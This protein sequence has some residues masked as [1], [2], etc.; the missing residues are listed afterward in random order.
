MMMKTNQ[1]TIKD[2]IQQRCEEDPK[3]KEAW[4]NRNP[5]GRITKR[6]KRTRVRLVKGDK[7]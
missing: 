5:K 2:H 1:I 6:E 4:E 7:F 3:F